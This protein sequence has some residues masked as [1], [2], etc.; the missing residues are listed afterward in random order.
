[1]IPKTIHYCWFGGKPKPKLAN[2]CIKSWQKYCKDY[3]IIEWNESNFDINCNQYVKE[4]YESK[5]WAFV[6]DYVR[7]W[8]MYTQGGVY[9]DTDV[10]LIKPLDKFLGEEAFSGFENEINIPTGIMAAEKGSHIIKNLL[11]YYDDASFILPDGSLN[12]CTN[13]ETITKM[14]TERGFVA[15]NTYQCV[16]GFAF[17]PK[18]YFCPKDPFTGLCNITENTVA[19]HHFDGSWLPTE[20]RKEKQDW[21]RS[22]QR[23][24]LIHAPNRFFIKL[25][26]NDFYNKLKH[27]IKRIIRK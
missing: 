27:C 1:M 8:A 2:K 9:M 13:V 16:D 4:A 10:E 18:E 17:Y 14:M 26:G 12:T 21:W 15:N 5:K 6:T 7:L 3:E 23:D 24:Y 11:S 25:F 19:I 20:Y 22:R